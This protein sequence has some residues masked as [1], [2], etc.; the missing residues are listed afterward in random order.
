[1]GDPGWLGARVRLGG[2]NVSTLVFETGQPGRVDHLDEETS[3]VT[4]LAREHGAR[5]SVGAPIEVEGRLWGLIIVASVHKAVLPPGTERELVAFTGLVATAIA[6]AQARTDLTA[7]RARI[8][9]SA[10]ETRRRIVRDLHDG[11][12]QR[13][14]H[15]ILT[16]ELA[17]HAQQSDDREAAT[18]LLAEA[19]EHAQRTN[20]ELRELVHGILPSVLQQGGLIAAVDE[21]VSRM[22]V[23]VSLDVTDDRFSPDVEANAYFVI[24][25]AL[26]NVAKHSGAR[27]AEVTARA[28]DGALYVEVRDDGVGGATP[29][30]AGLRGLGDRVAALGGQLQINSPVGAGTRLAARLP[31]R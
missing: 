20:R 26:T 2:H 22:R 13:V 25:E 10:D 24:A 27:H 18:A 1:V 15:T 16:L 8:V 4:A 17:Q 7:S 11:A 23:A 28:G 6:N 30:G 21:L 19:L 5:S 9:S 14:V 29:D 31:R 12:Q 3:A